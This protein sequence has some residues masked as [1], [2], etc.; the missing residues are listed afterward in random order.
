MDSKDSNLTPALDEFLGLESQ[1]NELNE[2]KVVRQD[3]SI[4]EKINKK[5]ITEDGRQLL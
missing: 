5:V 2:E 3:R 4:L 1:E